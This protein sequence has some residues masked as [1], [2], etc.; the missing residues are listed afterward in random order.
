MAAGSRRRARSGAALALA[1][2]A[3]LLALGARPAAATFVIEKGGLKVV[4]P[5]EAKAKYPSE[6]LRPRWVG[7]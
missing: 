3:A 7:H 5:E 4:L 1:L 6:C 2:A